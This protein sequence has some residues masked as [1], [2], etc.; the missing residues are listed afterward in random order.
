MSDA[1]GPPHT[2]VQ[3]VGAPL[4]RDDALGPVIAEALQARLPPG[5]AAVELEWGEGARLMARWAGFRRVIIVDAACSGAAPGTVHRIDARA[6]PVPTGLCYHS[7]H[8]FG[9]AEAI[10]VARVLGRLPESIRLYA[11]EGEAFGNGEGLSPAVARAADA[12]ADEL[13][14]ALAGG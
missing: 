6:R 5:R 11:V 10:E 7:T 1:P 4:R 13:V 12:L 9:V 3:C 14:E 2:L 8:R